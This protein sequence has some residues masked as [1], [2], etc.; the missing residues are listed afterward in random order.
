MTGFEAP[1]SSCA[2]QGLEL[3]GSQARM[4]RRKRH[5]LLPPCFS[6]TMPKFKPMTASCY[7]SEGMFSCRNSGRG[8]WPLLPRPAGGQKWY[9]T[10]K[11]LT[12]VDAM[13]C[14]ALPH[15]TA[16]LFINNDERVCTM[17]TRCGSKN[18][19]PTRR[20]AI[21]GP[22]A[23]CTTAPARTP[24]LNEVTGTPMR[25]KRNATCSVARD[26]ARGGGGGD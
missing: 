12:L 6:S 1:P 17:I 5:R 9:T 21:A 20:P 4:T 18:W 11:G 15:I 10:R 24:V 7:L 14:T 25:L 19:R 13:Q 8:L 16:S 26:G 23:G 3:P 22:L 2:G